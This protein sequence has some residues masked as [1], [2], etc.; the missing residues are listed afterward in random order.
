[1]TDHTTLSADYLRYVFS[2]VTPLLE[3]VSDH[4]CGF[5]PHAPAEHYEAHV[6]HVLELLDSCRQTIWEA[7][8]AVVA[9][10]GGV[11]HYADGR[12]VSTSIELE[13]GMT[14]VHDWHPDPGH[15]INQPHEIVTT[16]LSDGRSKR[17]IVVAPGVLDAIESGPRLRLVVDDECGDAR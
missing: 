13:P 3:A 4:I 6:D 1:M 11:H 10:R 8:N 5:E 16:D 17:I 7:V 12:P 9:G 15:A 14:F 2:E